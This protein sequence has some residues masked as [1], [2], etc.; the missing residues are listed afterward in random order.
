VTKVVQQALFACGL[1]CGMS[2][3]NTAFLIGEATFFFITKT[4]M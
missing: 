1:K 2:V 3:A 4:E